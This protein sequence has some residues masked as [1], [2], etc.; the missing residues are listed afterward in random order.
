MGH[1][2]IRL[3]L[4]KP[5]YWQAITDLASLIDVE[6]KLEVAFVSATKQTLYLADLKPL[7]LPIKLYTTPGSILSQFVLKPYEYVTENQEVI[8][9][10]PGD[11]VIDAGACWADTT[12]F[13]ANK[14]K[15]IGRVYSFEFI[16]NNLR[17][18]YK[19][20]K[21]NSELEKTIK[22]IENP[23]WNESGVKMFYCDNGPGS[24]VSATPFAGY[25]GEVYTISIDDFVNSEQLNKVDLIKMDIEGAEQFAL[26]GAENTLR[27]YKPQLAISVYHNMNDLANIVHLINDLNLGYKFYLNHFTIHYEETVLYGKV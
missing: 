5:E 4:S 20:I 23:L 10:K 1:R 17:M 25:E 12:L 13:F 6:D 18:A 14:V 7:D 2:K 11:I 9:A 3:P 27:K 8:G 24:I 21:L 26:K 15:K 22:I 19:N 16:P